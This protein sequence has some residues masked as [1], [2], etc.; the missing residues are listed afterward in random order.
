VACNRRSIMND[1]NAS[2]LCAGLRHATFQRCNMRRCDAAMMTLQHATL[3]QG[4]A[5]TRRGCDIARSQ[6]GACAAWAD[7]TWASRGQT[8]ASRGRTWC[9]A[10]IGADRASTAS[11]ERAGGLNWTKQ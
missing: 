2:Y 6:H 3:Q 1:T 5:A 4:G 8:L 7:V 11:S 9:D 10:H